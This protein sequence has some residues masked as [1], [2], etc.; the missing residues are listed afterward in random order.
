MVLARL[1]EVVG[2]DSDDHLD[3]LQFF[4]ADKEY[5]D[6]KEER[7]Y[8][9][10]FKRLQQNNSAKR[11][12]ARDPEKQ[13]GYNRNY[14]RK[15][16]A[17]IL[18]M[19]SSKQRSKRQQEYESNPVIN[20][21]LICGKVWSPPYTQSNRKARFCSPNCRAKYHHQFRKPRNK[22]ARDMEAQTKILEFVRENPGATLL[23]VATLTSRSLSAARSSLY[24]LRKI[25]KVSVAPVTQIGHFVSE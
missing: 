14:Y 18:A 20:Q 22:T 4:S 7:E 19:E 13:R 15:N 17:R 23:Q 24:V 12:R 2:F 5:Q 8:A 6:R 11:R 1:E 25:G 3:G 9:R 21:C 16:R 10:L